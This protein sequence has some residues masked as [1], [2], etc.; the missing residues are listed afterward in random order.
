M[1]AS[2]NAYQ[3]ACKSKVHA[4]IYASGRK[5]PSCLTIEI[6]RLNMPLPKAWKTVLHTIQNPA[7]TKLILMILSASIPILIISGVASNSNNN[8]LKLPTPIRCVEPG[9]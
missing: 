5:T 6:M 4:K 9:E 1:S 7:N 8:L 2:G 3:T